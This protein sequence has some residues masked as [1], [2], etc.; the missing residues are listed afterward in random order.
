MR[1]QPTVLGV[2]SPWGGDEHDRV[3]RSYRLWVRAYWFTRR[4]RHRFG[5]HDWRIRPVDHTR[6]HCD[7]CGD[8]RE[9][10]T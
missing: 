2:P 1:P 4:A 5:L 7:W 3:P 8:N 10:R 9:R 6:E